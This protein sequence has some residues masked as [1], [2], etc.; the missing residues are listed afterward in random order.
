MT[1][2]YQGRQPLDA[3]WQHGYDYGHQHAHFST[4]EPPDFSGWTHYGAEVQAALPGAWREGAQAGRT[5]ALGHAPTAGDNTDDGESLPG[6][7][8]TPAAGNEPVDAA[9]TTVRVHQVKFWLNAFIQPAHVDGPPGAGL[10]LNY[11]YFSGDNRSYSTDIHA[12]SRLHSEVEIVGIETGHPHV[13]FQWHNC[14]ES[15]ALDSS[16]NVVATERATPSGGFGDPHYAD[17][18]VSI[19]YVGAAAMPLLPSPDVDI[20]GTFSVNVE[21]GE[22]SFHGNIDVYPWYEA[23]VTVNNGAPVALFH[24]VP[25]GTPEQLVGGAS[26]PVSGTAHTL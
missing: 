16:F 17:G 21:T 11:E 8:L 15:H 3:A 5:A 24:E 14:G 6:G 1:N 7:V 2:P 19:G 4:P 23:Y 18:V 10:A 26:R 20:N 9:H 22:A 13:S 12:S 25:S